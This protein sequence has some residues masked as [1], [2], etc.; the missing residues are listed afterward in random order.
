MKKGVDFIGV[1]VCAIIIN[2]DEK[3]FVS[4]RGPKSRNEVGKWEFPGGAVEFGE[5]LQK[6]VIREMKEEF[7]LEVKIIDTL[8]VANHIL[9]EEKQHWV[10]TGFV[11]KIAKGVPEINEP[12][13]SGKIG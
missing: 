2:K 11:C 8:G 1:G 3:L 10:T 7:G 4:L 5:T 13:K 12:L 6:A 9:P